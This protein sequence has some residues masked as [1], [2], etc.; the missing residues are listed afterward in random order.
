MIKDSI[1]TCCIRSYHFEHSVFNHLSLLSPV[2][3]LYIPEVHDATTPEVEAVPVAVVSTPEIVPEVEAAPV[4]VV[5]TPEIVPEV[6]AAP[7]AVVSTP[8]IVPEVAA[9]P[10]AVV[11]TPEIVPEAPVELVTILPEMSSS[12]EILPEASAD[13]VLVTTASVVRATVSPVTSSPVI[14]KFVGWTPHFM[15]KN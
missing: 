3:F 6:A 14:A 15:T 12:P 1:L 11:S 5:S 10:V 9:A 13:P 2:R 8:E 4:A 7:V